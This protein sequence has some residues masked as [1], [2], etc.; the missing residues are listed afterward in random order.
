MMY[1]QAEHDCRGMTIRL[2]QVRTSAENACAY[3][4]NSTYAHIASDGIS[5]LEGKWPRHLQLLETT[6]KK[7][8]AACSAVARQVLAF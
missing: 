2:I 5:G 4:W 8:F 1:V 6:I 3:A 7:E